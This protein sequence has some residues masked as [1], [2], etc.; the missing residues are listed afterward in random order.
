MKAKLFRVASVAAKILCCAGLGIAYMSSASALTMTETYTGSVTAGSDT[1]NLFGLNGASLVG[2]QYT[3]TYT[4][5]A[6]LGTGILTCNGCGGGT[7]V[8]LNSNG[9]SSPLVSASLTINNISFSISGGYSGLT[10]F[11]TCQQSCPP[12]SQPYSIITA[13]AGGDGG[14]HPTPQLFSILADEGVLNIPMSVALL[15]TNFIFNPL[16]TNDQRGGLR[17]NGSDYVDFFNE[18]SVT[19][20]LCESCGVPI[21]PPSPTPLPAS[22]PLFAAG[23][24]VMGLLG[25]RRKRKQR[26]FEWARPGGSG[27]INSRPKHP[28]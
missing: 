9:S 14:A 28:Q 1:S 22:L 12:G 21:I 23:L 25:W 27:R 24:G 3:A 26:P 18:A 13:N 16:T 4:F 7:S 8:T 2:Q 6:G 15:T 17:I 5:D 10:G 20:V 19:L 11:Y